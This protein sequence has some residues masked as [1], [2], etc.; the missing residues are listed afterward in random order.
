MNITIQCIT[1]LL[2]IFIW[3]RA[4]LVFCVTVYPMHIALSI[5]EIQKNNQKFP[6]YMST[7]VN[8]MDQ[9]KTDIPTNPKAMAGAYTLESH[10]SSLVLYSYM[11]DVK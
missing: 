1:T 11:E 2:Y 10:V 7:I 9:D 6:T 5:I 8:E 3:V 4:R